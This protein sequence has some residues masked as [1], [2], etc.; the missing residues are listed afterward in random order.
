MA[1]GLPTVATHIGGLGD[2]II[3]GYNGLLAEPT[4]ESIGR[5]LRRLVE[6]GELREVMGKRGRETA[7]AFGRDVWRGRWMGLLLASR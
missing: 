3:D 5:C 6:N 7:E 4:S 2:L 1:I